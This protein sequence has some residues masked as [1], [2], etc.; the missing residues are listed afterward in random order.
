MKK[1]II[2]LA[3]PVILF[4]FTTCNLKQH[5]SKE[6]K[7]TNK[8]P[9]REQTDTELRRLSSP[10]EML[11]RLVVLYNDLADEPMIKDVNSLSEEE[12]LKKRKK[13]KADRINTFFKSSDSNGL[14]SPFFSQRNLSGD[15][16]CYSGL[17]KSYEI[18]SNEV[19]NNKARVFINITNKSTDEYVVEFEK[20]ND[21]WKITLLQDKS[22]WEHF[23]R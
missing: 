1:L 13:I 11:K 15:Y 6:Q 4:T 16:E 9:K 2:A 8:E 21:E 17:I 10:E 5:D 19:F 12:N 3:L 7:D 23:R 20:I 22:W 14:F 18:L